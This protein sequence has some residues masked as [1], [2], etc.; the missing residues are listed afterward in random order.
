MNN[1]MNAQ[2]RRKFDRLVEKRRDYV[3]GHRSNEFPDDEISTRDE[4]SD[5]AH[6]IYELLQNADD[7]EATEVKFVLTKDKL[8][9]YHNGREFNY[10]DID[11]VTGR[12][13]STKKDDRAKIGKFGRGFKSVFEVTDTPYIFSGIYKIKI[14]DFIVP[15]EELDEKWTSPKTL[16]RLPFNYSELSPEKAFDEISGELESLDPKTL[17]FLRK[18][19]EIK[20][21][22]KRETSNSEGNY[23]REFRDSKTQKHKVVQRHKP[24]DVKIVW[25]NSSHH[26]KKEKYLVIGCP[27]NIEDHDS[28]HDLLVEVAFKLGEKGITDAKDSRLVVFFP[29]TRET[30]LKFIVQG[31]FVTTKN[32]EGI[33]LDKDENPQIKEKIG[34]LVAESLPIIRDLGYL[35]TDFLRLLPI[36]TAIDNP[37]YSCVRNKI[38]EK[39]ISEELLPTSETSK[40]KY[41]NPAD[42]AIGSKT[43]SELL[44]PEDLKKLYFG[45]YLKEEKAWLDPNI[46]GELRKYLTSE[47]DVKEIS[48]YGFVEKITELEHERFL[49]S[50][51]NKWMI[52][53]Y[54]EL[55]K[56]EKLWMRGEYNWQRPILWDAPIVKLDDGRCMAPFV[57]EGEPRKD[58]PQVYLPLNPKVGYKSGYP[59]VKASLAK[60]KE[61]LGF[62]ENLGLKIPG[63]RAEVRD[64][65]LPKYRNGK[66]TQGEQ[67][68]GD[69]LKIMRARDDTPWNKKDKFIDDLKGIPFILAVK[70]GTREVAFK[71]PGEVYI[72]SDSLEEFF[73]GYESTYFVVGELLNKDEDGAKREFLEQLGVKDK[74]RRIE[75]NDLTWEEREKLI[76]GVQYWREDVKDYEYEGLDNLIDRGMTQKKSCLLWKLLLASVE[77]FTPD[78]SN[79]EEG[80]FKGSYRWVPRTRWNGPRWFDS[81]FLRTLLDSD[82]L[83]DKNDEFRRSSDLTLSE[84]SDDYEKSGWNASIL[85]AQ[86]QFKPELLPEE[87][88]IVDLE[89]ENDELKREKENLK[90]ENDELKKNLEKYEDKKSREKWEPEVK[91]DEVSPQI[92][93][94]KSHI[95]NNIELRI[96]ENERVKKAPPILKPAKQL[97]DFDE[98]EE[99]LQNESLVDKQ[100]IGEWSEKVVYKALKEKYGQRGEVIWLNEKGPGGDH[101]MGYDMRVEEN[102]SVTMY[103][104]VKG[105]TQSDPKSIEVQ[106]TQWTR[107]REL[108]ERGEGEKFC[109]Y[110]VSN[111]GTS[112][113]KIKPPIRNP[114]GG[115]KEGWLQAHPVRLKLPKNTQDD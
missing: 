23:S 80:F 112:S 69:F 104:E 55:S 102:S 96:H 75:K 46:T 20:W 15:C 9:T 94:P 60:D 2:E 27:I 85:I 101:R 79:P 17:L 52:K 61:V 109:F 88:K 59:T 30:S 68:Y 26:E 92:P 21:E 47:L 74:P 12:G 67:Y 103:V 43:L 86:F 8:E 38:R 97:D 35:N 54:K 100:A 11:G 41:V 31:P 18:I 65:V 36:S 76:D 49:Q 57:G 50:R 107:A 25:L 81:K 42:S 114:Y 95:S 34:E 71:T 51:N 77:D 87:Q 40:K 83:V 113:V 28:S 115:W 32:R 110:V 64:R 108:Y 6:F 72:S 1:E 7:A 78:S 10:D 70:N 63:I 24:Y 106:G 39:L 91:P 22:I 45:K 16:I 66:G 53:F 3:D 99:E 93:E 82:W 44:P 84:L 37:I 4:N 58:E 33:N 62:L 89:R 5:L 13:K 14:V 105:T 29:T 111:A 90:Q 98:T 56:H 19:N 73:E 48:L